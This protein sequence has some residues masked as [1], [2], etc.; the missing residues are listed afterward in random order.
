MAKC[1]SLKRKT[2]NRNT[3]AFELLT[4]HFKLNVACELPPLYLKGLSFCFY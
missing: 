2:K 1:G 3:A 4:C